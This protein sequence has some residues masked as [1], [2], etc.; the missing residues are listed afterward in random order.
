MSE[1]A[2]YAWQQVPLS[3]D[4]VW[5]FFFPVC[6]FCFFQLGKV[7]CGGTHLPLILV[8]ER[9]RQRQVSLCAL[10]RVQPSLHS[11]TLSRKK[12]DKILGA[13]C[14]FSGWD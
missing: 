7:R 11:D 4:P 10:V 13:R 14:Q 9:Q 6:L 2:H 8:L 1:L 12:E 3:V 5:V